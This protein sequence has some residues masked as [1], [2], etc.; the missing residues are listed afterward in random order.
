MHHLKSRAL[1]KS[2]LKFSSYTRLRKL[3]S[4]GKSGPQD[5]QLYSPLRAWLWLLSTSCL[6]SFYYFVLALRE[7]R[8][9]DSSRM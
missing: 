1:V 8:V 9:Y 5:D 7:E 4:L 2:A 3:S 6:L